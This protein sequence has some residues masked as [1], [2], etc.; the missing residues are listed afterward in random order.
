VSAI[1]RAGTVT[2]HDSSLNIY[3]EGIS[4]ARAG[5]GHAGVKTW[6]R[7]FKRDV[8]GRIVQTLNRL[9]WTCTMPAI[10]AHDIKHYGGN[11]ARWSAESKRDCVKGDLKAHLDI[12]GRCIKLE[13]WQDV[14]PSENRNGGRYDFDKAARMPYLLRIEM[15][16]TRR[17]IRDYLCNVFVGYV[18]K[19]SDPKIGFNGVTA[20]EFAAH[21]RRTSGHYVPALDRASIS[22]SGQ[23]KSGDGYPL[24]NGTPVYAIDY[25]GRVVTG[26]AFY[27][28]NGNW[29]VITGRYDLI[30]VWHK[31]IFV[32]S[33]GNVQA[34]R[35]ASQRRKRLES[36]MSKAVTAMKFERA[37]QLRDILFPGDQQLFNVWHDGHSLYHCAGFSGYTADQSKAGKFTAD[38]V[39]GWDCAPNRV[40]SI[41]RELEAA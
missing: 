25:Y 24:E 23:D 40:V 38:E 35:N 22:N 4:A 27:S 2:F 7:Q 36:E 9:G 31:Q 29:Q 18:F 21:G 17:R 30:H 5:G 8:F 11:V 14:T 1:A 33:P 37:A 10:S 3:E 12:S 39:Q 20:L 19:P 13:M 41:M 15:E 26:V 32:K 16:R 28:L 34:R 6:E